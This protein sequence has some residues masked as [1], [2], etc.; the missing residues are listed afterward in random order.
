VK[1]KPKY[2]HS[3]PTTNNESGEDVTLSN[4]NETDDDE[5]TQPTRPGIRTD[6]QPSPR[7]NIPP[8]N[9]TSGIGALVNANIRPSTASTASTISAVVRATPTT[10]KFDSER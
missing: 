5:D 6:I 2:D 8:A 10:D 9:T 7:K 4:A 3:R 1:S